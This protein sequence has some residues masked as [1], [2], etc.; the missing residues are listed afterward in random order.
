MLVAEAE[1]AVAETSVMAEQEDLITCVVRR[2][3]RGGEGGSKGRLD[4][5]AVEKQIALFLET[6]RFVSEMNDTWRERVFRGVVEF[7]PEQEVAIKT[8]F[9]QLA[10]WDEKIEQLRTQLRNPKAKLRD[11]ATYQEYLNAVRQTL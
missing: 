7:N 11:W 8:C 6:F 4:P 9:E 3:K 5:H 1:S 10:A 2:R